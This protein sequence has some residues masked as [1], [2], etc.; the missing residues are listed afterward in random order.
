[1]PSLVEIDLVVL[2]KIFLQYIFPN[3]H[4]SPLGKL[5]ALHLN[6]PESHSNKDALCKDDCN[7]LN[8]SGEGDFL[9]IVNIF[10]LFHNYLL[11]EKVVAFHLNKPLHKKKICPKFG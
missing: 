6:K 10:S 9:K 5:G 2:E 4:L 11:L 1:M 3:S 8:G 7:W